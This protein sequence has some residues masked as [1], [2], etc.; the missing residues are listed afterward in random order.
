MLDGN[1]VVLFQYQSQ[2]IIIAS[3]KTVPVDILERSPWR[4]VGRF[5]R[6]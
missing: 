6:A 2:N 5:R 3:F 1:V 4:T